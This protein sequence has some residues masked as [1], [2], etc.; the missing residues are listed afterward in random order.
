MRKLD[1]ELDESLRDELQS[2]IRIS[3]LE[4]Q[5][6]KDKLRSYYKVPW[7]Q[8]KTKMSKSLTFFKAKL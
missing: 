2:K 1:V 6:K 5:Q 4:T 7:V 8:V 3:G